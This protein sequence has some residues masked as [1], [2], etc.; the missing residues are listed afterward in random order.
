MSIDC[1]KTQTRGNLGDFG[2]VQLPRVH[3]GRISAHRRR[4][5]SRLRAQ[6]IGRRPDGPVARLH[7]GQGANRVPESLE[8][9]GLASEAGRRRRAGQTK[10]AG[11]ATSRPHRTGATVRPAALHTPSAGAARRSWPAAHTRGIPRVPRRQRRRRSANCRCGGLYRNLESRRLAEVSRR[12]DAEIP[13]AFRSTVAIA[14]PCT[15]YSLPASVFLDSKPTA[16]AHR[17]QSHAHIKANISVPGSEKFL[18]ND[19][20]R[21]SVGVASQR[22]GFFGTTRSVHPCSPGPGTD[23]S[24]RRCERPS[25]CTTIN[26][27]PKCYIILFRLPLQPVSLVSA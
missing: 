4:T 17:A 7:I 5:V 19:R 8:R 2:Y 6:R 20:P 16:Q 26:F 11:R 18:G 25:I 21:H 9:P 23:F 14:P 24:D 15:V 12:P 1:P 13:T 3:I 10:N 27:C 22:N